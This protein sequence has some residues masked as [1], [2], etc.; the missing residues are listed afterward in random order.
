MKTRTIISVL[1]ALIAITFYQCAKD[2]HETPNHAAA[3]LKAG[4]A[5]DSLEAE[6][7]AG[8][9]Q[10]MMESEGG[11]MRTAEPK[12]KDTTDFNAVFLLIHEQTTHPMTERVYHRL[13]IFNGQYQPWICSMCYIVRNSPGMVPL[14]SGIHIEAASSYIDFPPAGNGYQTVLTNIS[15]NAIYF[16]FFSLAPFQLSW[17]NKIVMETSYHITGPGPHWVT[18]DRSDP[19]N[20]ALSNDGYTDYACIAFPDTLKIN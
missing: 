11:Q 10:R 17:A 12:A 3:Y 7:R 4:I 5:N 14:A 2:R 19:N 18:L 20:F 16:V 9:M 8:I 13:M 6:I 1:L 15:S